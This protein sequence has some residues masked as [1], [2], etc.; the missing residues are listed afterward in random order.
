MN[1]DKIT[2]YVDQYG[3]TVLA[4]TVKELQQKVGG[5][6]SKVYEDRC[7]KTYHV[8]Y[9]IGDRWFSSWVTKEYKSTEGQSESDE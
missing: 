2:L 1:G 6:L 5:T 9:R 3:N 7:G 8:G 4:R